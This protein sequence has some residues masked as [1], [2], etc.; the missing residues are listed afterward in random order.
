M[1]RIDLRLDEQFSDT[2]SKLYDEKDKL[3]GERVFAN[4]VDLMVFSA[5]V[6]R[7]KFDNCAD[8]KVGRGRAISSDVIQNLHGDGVAYLLAL[9]DKN[10][11]NILRE[12]NDKEMWEY[13]QNY[14]FLG[15]QEIDKWI[16]GTGNLGADPKDIILQKMKDIAIR[17][18]L[19]KS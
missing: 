8:V 5:M 15:L 18:G 7:D 11:G 13:I 16:N 10:D 9:D 14:A 19:N 2:I 3:T 4:L 1:P 12:E 17:D 6:G